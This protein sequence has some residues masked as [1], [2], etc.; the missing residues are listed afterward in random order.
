[1]QNLIFRFPTALQPP[2]GLG[3]LQE[4]PPSFP[5]YGDYCSVSTCLVVVLP[6]VRFSLYE[7][8][9]QE[10]FTSL[11]SQSNVQPPTWRTSVPLLVWPLPFDLTAK[12]DPT[13]SYTT[14]GI[15]LRVIGVLKPPYHDKVEAPAGERSLIYIYYNT[16]YMFRRNDHHY[17]VLTTNTGIV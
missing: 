11:E 9:Q 14:G 3:L 17:Q 2:V 15:A 12:G 8:P 5:V 6:S 4:F 16:Y 7:L 10:D 1:M 13:S